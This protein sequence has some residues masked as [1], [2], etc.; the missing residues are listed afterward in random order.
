MNKRPNKWVKLTPC[1]RWDHQKVAA[2]F[3]VRAIP[4]LLIFNEGQVA[5]QIVGM[6]SK[7]DLKGNLDKF[8]S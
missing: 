8:C 4:T 5:E 7:R 1:G 6:R 2:D 3:G